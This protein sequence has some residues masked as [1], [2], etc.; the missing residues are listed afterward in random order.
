MFLNIIISN[1]QLYNIIMSSVLSG[2]TGISLE[3]FS[4]TYGGAEGDA[5]TTPMPTPTA[6]PE[7]STPSQ[8]VVTAPSSDDIHTELLSMHENSSEAHHHH[9]KNTHI[10]KHLYGNMQQ[11]LVGIYLLMMVVVMLWFDVTLEA[12]LITQTGTFISIV[13]FGIFI[14]FEFLKYRALR[15]ARRDAAVA[16]K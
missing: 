5:A 1:N 4:P 10:I 3:P 15:D 9:S 8:P 13:G 7:I 16:K 14:V 12:D 6:S 2:G 11:L